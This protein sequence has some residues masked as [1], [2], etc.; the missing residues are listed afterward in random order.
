[1]VEAVK[2]VNI[3]QPVVAGNAVK[4]Q[5]KRAMRSVPSRKPVYKR[6]PKIE[7]WAKG[8][9][10]F[11]DVAGGTLSCTI[12]GEHK[13]YKDGDEYSEPLA[14]F[15]KMNEE[16]KVVKRRHVSGGDNHGAFVKTNRYEPR[17]WWEITER[18]DKKTIINVVD[19]AA[20]K[21][22]NK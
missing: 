18:F 15:E 4:R 7:K 10:H 11:N 8:I 17:L 20:T 16:C 9:F 2:K 5:V 12:Q 19:E 22:Q 14:V 1:M 3:V 13:S 21:A 6:V